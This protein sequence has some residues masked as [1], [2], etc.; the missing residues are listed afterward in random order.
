MHHTVPIPGMHAS[1]P[2]TPF[3]SSPSNGQPMF[4]A[5]NFQASQLQDF[6]SYTRPKRNG[7]VTKPKR[8]PRPPNAFILYRK[9]K[10]AEVI[11]D[12]PGVSNKDVSCIIGQMWKS[13]DPP[14]R[15]SLGSRPKWRKKSTRAASKLQVSATQAQEQAPA[16]GP[17]GRRCCVQRVF[18]IWPEPRWQL[19]IWNCPHGW[20]IQRAFLGNQGLVNLRQCQRVIPAVLQIPSD[21]AARTRPAAVGALADARLPAACARFARRRVL[22]PGADQMVDPQQ[23]VNSSFV[24]VAPQLD[25]KPNG[26]VSGIPNTAYWTPNTPGDGHSPTPCPPEMC[27]M[28]TRHRIC[29]HLI[30]LLSSTRLPAMQWGHRLHICSIHLTTNARHKLRHRPSII[31]T[32]ITISNSTSRCTTAADLWT[33]R[34]DSSSNTTSTTDI[35]SNTNSSRPPLVA[36]S[37]VASRTTTRSQAWTAWTVR[38]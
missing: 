7:R 28:A 27:S 31:I 6:D 19:C 1:T 36:M 29:V 23:H 12:N 18:G 35:L 22:L 10:Q 20:L 33:T 26:F 37:M 25:I 8:T 34:L 30:H 9:A 14:F 17:G 16:G 3:G 32:I 11:R 21:D 24:G 38:Q 5:L 15:I 4:G 2:Q 13:E